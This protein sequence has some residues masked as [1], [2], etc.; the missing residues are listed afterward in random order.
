MAYRRKLGL[1]QLSHVQ[2]AVTVGIQAVKFR[3][4]EC[5]ELGFGNLPA[6]VGIHQN[7]KS[8]RIRLPRGHRLRLRRKGRYSGIRPLS[9]GRLAHYG[10]CSN[11][12]AKSDRNRDRGHQEIAIPFERHGILRRPYLHFEFSRTQGEYTPHPR[13]CEA[14]WR[15]LKQPRGA[16]GM[17]ESG[18]DHIAKRPGLGSPGP[19]ASVEIAVASRGLC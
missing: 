5:H 13:G 6:S 8:L 17:T 10:R 9:C 3:G 1:F 19:F 2:L 16:A 14:L 11:G 4:H 12:R 18:Q 7:Q 15:T